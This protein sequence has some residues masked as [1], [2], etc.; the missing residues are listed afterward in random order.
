MLDRRSIAARAGLG[1]AFLLGGCV[2]PEKG[3]AELVIDRLGGYTFTYT[4]GMAY[5]LGLAAKA[6]G[7]PLS[8]KDTR[9]IATALQGLSKDKEFLSVTPAG[10]SRVNVQ[11]KA[12]RKPG[13]SFK[14]LGDT[15]FITVKEDLK[16]HRLTITS[17]TITPKSAKQM[18]Q[19]GYKP[20][21]TLVVKS[22]LPVLANNGSSQRTLIFGSTS[23]KW[24]I[25]LSR[26]AP[27]KMVVKLPG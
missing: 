6:S 2:G 26:S 1:L 23:Y 10:F 14:F 27:V 21:V 12:V 5:I 8:A 25:D 7:K 22:D 17:P 16:T 24:H 3:E 19:V 11:Y 18:Q 15:S 20:D 13:Q 4:G 9:G